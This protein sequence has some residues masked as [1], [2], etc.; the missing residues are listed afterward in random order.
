MFFSEITQKLQIMKRMGFNTKTLLN[1]LLLLLFCGSFVQLYGQKTKKIEKFCERIDP[2]NWYAQ[3]GN[4]TLQLLFY[5]SNIAQSNFELVGFGAELIGGDQSMGADYRLQYI[6]L[7]STFVGNLKFRFQKGENVQVIE[8]EIR[9]KPALGAMDP[10]QKYH[11]SP[12]DAMYL[13]MPDRFANGDPSN[14]EVDGMLEGLSPSDPFG[15]HGG[16][17]MGIQKELPYIKE[18]GFT[19]LWLTPFWENNQPSQSYHGY[20]CTDL[21]RA[22][23]RYGTNKDYLDLCRKARDLDI[24]MVFDVVYNH[25]GHEHP[26]Y[27][28]PVDTNW[29]HH[30]TEK[31]ITNYRLATL[32]DPY[33]LKTERENMEKG[34]FVTEMPDWNQTNPHVAQY[35]IQNTLWWIANAQLAGIRVDTYPYSESQFLETLNR[36]LKNTFPKVFLFGETWE[37]TA[38]TQAVYAPNILRIGTEEGKPSSIT[39]FQVCFALQKGLQEPWA[40]D[41]GLSRLYY[42]L[43]SDYLYKQPEYLVTFIDNHDINRIH[44][45]F[46]KERWKTK[47]ALGLLTMTR[48]IP[49]TFYGTECLMSS[50]ESHGT[51]R[52]DM[53]GGFPKHTRSVFK[54]TERVDFE[55]EMIRWI[56]NLNT[57]RTEAFKGYFDSGKRFQMVPN[58]GLYAA[59][60]EGNKSVLLYAANQ[61]DKAE[62]LD[63]NSL[64]DLGVGLGKFRVLLV[65]TDRKDDFIIN[66]QNSQFESGIEFSELN[67][68]AGGI[69][70]NP[71]GSWEV[72]PR[73]FWILELFK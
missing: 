28:N 59:G 7:D 2:P 4:D 25:V 24:K 55:Q 45:Q 1:A 42:A 72:P 21:Y 65:S 15:R 9:Q 46:G 67:E 27:K 61:S 33:V 6:R 49:C 47:M 22:D 17:L 13:V 73:S 20:A 36:R 30:Y 11:L 32:I 71:K 52:E 26:L 64:K 62:S 57:L 51:I 48:G 43:A 41:G 37:V 63:I 69:E 54:P 18:M 16:D 19:S 70:L 60:I 38:A 40:W 44:G 39:D 35:L 50:Q 29:F 58:E 5:G 56:S 10:G 66:L 8:Y 68:G 31:R 3:M 23:P 34:W 14:D 12:S 53:P